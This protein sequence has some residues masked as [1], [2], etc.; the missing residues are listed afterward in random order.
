MI[1]RPRYAGLPFGLL[2]AV[3]GAGMVTAQAPL[4][5]RGQGPAP[6]RQGQAP[7]ALPASPV[8][9]PLAGISAAVAGPGEMF[10]A[11]MSLP[12]G[13]DMPHFKYVSTEYFVTGTA[14]N[15]PY[16]TRIVVRKP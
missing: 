13:D 4:P 6:G 3:L 7:P 16:K 2:L 11:L 14:N 9:A 15:A 8:A 5:V 12:A 10:P 1:L